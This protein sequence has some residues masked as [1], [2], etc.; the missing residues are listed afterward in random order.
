[1][2]EH[3]LFYVHQ[4]GPRGAVVSWGEEKLQL[5]FQFAMDAAEETCVHPYS[6]Q[7]KSDGNVSLDG[8]HGQT[9]VS[10]P[11]GSNPSTNSPVYS[12]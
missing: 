6:L 3:L 8:Q 9:E 2:V 1:M 7:L 11:S 4:H 10:K 12:T 5:V